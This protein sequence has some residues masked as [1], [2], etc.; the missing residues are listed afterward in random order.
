MNANEIKEILDLHEKWLN[1]LKDGKRADLREAYLQGAY[2][3]QAD[4]QEANLREANL[5][6][7]DL[8]GAYLQQAD[9]QEANLQRAH[10]RGAYLQ[11]AHLQ[12]ANLRGADLQGADLQGAYLQEADLQEADLREANLRGA[13]LQGADLQGADLLPDLY[14]LKFQSADSKLRAWKFLKVDST[15]PYQGHR[16]EVGQSYVADDFSTDERIACDKGLNVATLQWCL[17]NSNSED[18]LFIE[19]E[20]LAGDIIAVPLAT[21]GKFRV[22][23]LKVLRQITKAKAKKIIEDVMKPYTKTDATKGI[24]GR[25]P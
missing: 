16:Y 19:V 20:F 7:A 13:D 12:E 3:Q 25:T 15:S 4:L 23:A 11:Q 21:D 2:L 1:G 5:Q 9:L 24:E 18:N 17:R 14:I 10:L 22:K 8:R 6:Q